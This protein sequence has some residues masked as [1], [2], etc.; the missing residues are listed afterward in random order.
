MTDIQG[1]DELDIRRPS[2]VIAPPP[3]EVPL[4]C[5]LLPGY[6]LGAEAIRSE[7]HPSPRQYLRVVEQRE[8]RI[9]HWP[10]AKLAVTTII[11]RIAQPFPDDV[12][13][14]NAKKLRAIVQLKRAAGRGVDLAE[15][16]ALRAY[17]AWT[18]DD[19][20]PVEDEA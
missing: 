15:V 16:A 4:R 9:G 7:E 5:Y 12:A 20:T 10:F 11:E 14:I 2:P 19:G 3:R 13:A 18:S 1:F 8:E 6:W 17:R